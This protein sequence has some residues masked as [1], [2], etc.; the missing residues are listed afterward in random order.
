MTRS[1]LCL[2][3]GGGLFSG[4]RE[5]AIFDIYVMNAD[6]SGVKRL[7]DRTGY[8]GGPWFSPDGK[9]IAW[10]A[11][12][13]QTEEEKAM[14]RTAWRRIILSRFARYMGHGL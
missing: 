7:T 4:R 2:L 9:K 13:P 8:D 11:W 5:K 1:R 12:Y 10:R 6:G 14:W 3:T